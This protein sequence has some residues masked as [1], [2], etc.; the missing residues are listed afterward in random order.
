MSCTGSPQYL[1]KGG[2]VSWKAYWRSAEGVGTWSIASC[3]SDGGWEQ[4]LTSS[5]ISLMCSV[6]WW[7]DWWLMTW[8]LFERKRSW[9][10]DLLWRN[11]LGGTEEKHNKLFRILSRLRFELNIFWMQCTQT[12]SYPGIFGP[13]SSWEPWRKSCT[14]LAMTQYIQGAAS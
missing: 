3:R 6:E 4:D 8:N 5:S 13:E 12:C 7:D 10:N 14:I 2:S 1:L 11:L 9:R